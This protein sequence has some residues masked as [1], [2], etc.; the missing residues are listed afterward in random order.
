MQFLLAQSTQ[1]VQAFSSVYGFDRH[2]DAHLGCDLD[3]NFSAHT[4][5]L[6]STNSAAATPFIWIRILPWAPSNSTTHS[7]MRTAA[8]AISSTNPGNSADFRSALAGCTS[9]FSRM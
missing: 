6:S 5:R 2:Q 8:G 7:A 1:R 9:F 3:H 4:I